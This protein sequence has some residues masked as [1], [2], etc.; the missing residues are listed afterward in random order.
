MN[1]KEIKKIIEQADYIEV[2]KAIVSYEKD[3]NNEKELNNI[4]DR[5][6][7]SDCCGL[8]DMND[9]FEECDY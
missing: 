5:F 4:Y 2:V 6:M 3:I 8:F 7:D 1:W 9:I